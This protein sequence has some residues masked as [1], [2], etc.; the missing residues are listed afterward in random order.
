MRGG[1][2]EEDNESMEGGMGKGRTVKTRGGICTRK[3][4]TSDNNWV[5]HALSLLHW[6]EFI[7]P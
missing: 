7:K 6:Y 5:T 2:G 3:T 4:Q 1:K